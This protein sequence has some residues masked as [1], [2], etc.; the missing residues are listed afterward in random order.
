MAVIAGPMRK[1]GVRAFRS[2]RG[3]GL[4]VVAMRGGWGGRIVEV[5]L[6]ESG[7]SWRELDWVGLT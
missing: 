6:I 5:T 1:M 7:R 2:G 3:G 4:N